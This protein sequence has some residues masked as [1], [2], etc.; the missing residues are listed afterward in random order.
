MRVAAAAGT[1]A[2][3]TALRRTARPRP[4]A[5]HAAVR[6]PAGRATRTGRRQPANTDQTL[7]KPAARR[8]RR[9]RGGGRLESTGPGKGAA[10][11]AH[12]RR[13][14]M[15]E[16]RHERRRR[17]AAGEHG[18][19]GDYRQADG[20]GHQNRRASDEQWR[21]RPSCRATADSADDARRHHG[22]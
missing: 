6:S 17:A 21:R 19:D 14:S 18:D 12:E 15:A 11:R 8:R 4:A 5:H 3:D 13:T 1:D 16:R 20:H 9:I 7:T 22:G 10:C 2:T